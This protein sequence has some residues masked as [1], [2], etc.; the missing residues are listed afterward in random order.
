MKK[1]KIKQ[2]PQGWFTVYERNNIPYILGF[3]V[4]MAPAIIRVT[5]LLSHLL[6]EVFFHLYQI[7]LVSVSVTVPLVYF[8]TKFIYLN[9]WKYLAEFPTLDEAI[10]YVEKIK[11]RDNNTYYL[12]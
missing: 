10:E 2:D 4:L 12:N 3:L 5:S 1:Y 9:P 7:L 11:D 8:H 6:A